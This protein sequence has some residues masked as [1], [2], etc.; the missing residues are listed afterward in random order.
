MDHEFI[1]GMDP[2]PDTHTACVVDENGKVVHTLRVKTPEK[3]L[4]SLEDG[5][6]ASRGAYG[7]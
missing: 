6:P 4:R 2:H 7:P 1:V 3:A 5:P